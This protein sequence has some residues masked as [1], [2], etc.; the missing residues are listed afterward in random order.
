MITNSNNTGGI[1]LLPVQTYTENNFKFNTNMTPTGT[2]KN[3]QPG[4][5]SYL[6]PKYL[7]DPILFDNQ[8][9]SY[10]SRY[11]ADQDSVWSI[12]EFD[13]TRYS[14][15]TNPQYLMFNTE[16]NLFQSLTQRACCYGFTG[17]LLGASLLSVTAS[18]TSN[19]ARVLYCGNSLL[20]LGNNSDSP[21]IAPMSPVLTCPKPSLANGQATMI[22]L[23]MSNLVPLPFT[24]FVPGN[25]AP[26]PGSNFL[27]NQCIVQTGLTKPS[28]ALSGLSGDIK[29]F[30]DTGIPLKTNYTGDYNTSITNQSRTGNFNL[31]LWGDVWVP[32]HQDQTFGFQPDEF[33]PPVSSITGWD[34]TGDK[35]PNEF[36]VRA[37]NF[38]NYSY[39]SNGSE[40]YYYS[41]NSV[42]LN[43][44]G[45]L[46]GGN[47][48]GAGFS[49]FTQ[50][51][52]NLYKNK[53][54]E[55][56]AAGFQAY[57]SFTV[58]ETRQV[59]FRSGNTSTRYLWS[60]TTNTICNAGT[61]LSSLYPGGLQASI[62]N[63][64]QQFSY[65]FILTFSQEV[66]N[67]F[68]QL[69]VND[70]I[71]TNSYFPT[72]STR[73]LKNNNL[74]ASYTYGSSSFNSTIN[75]TNRNDIHEQTGI[76]NSAIAAN[77]PTGSTFELYDF[78]GNKVPPNQTL[79]INSSYSVRVYEFLTRN[80][81]GAANFSP[82]T[83][84]GMPSL[85]QSACPY[86]NSLFKDFDWSAHYNLLVPRGCRLFQNF[87]SSQFINSAPPGWTVD[88]Y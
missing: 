70:V 43:F 88:I 83:K 86:T 81:S 53:Y 19:T 51:V 9:A 28:L 20:S 22:P 34:P 65:N 46:W 66:Q 24:A 16:T 55:N 26:L 4:S 60:V 76:C 82:T 10:S 63:F 61:E 48:S 40:S 25:L 41:F 71:A 32:L 84:T 21:L 1:S 68:S 75:N 54:F 18:L 58:L 31:G 35:L 2:G 38:L 78:S 37:N 11:D 8:P 15:S 42:S 30:F 74:L 62:G 23:S 49:A 47:A 67:T 36:L 72:R 3:S 79:P 56:N 27:P 39:P 57:H 7:S 45:L 33:S 44:A 6:Y 59:D 29:T 17:Y 5:L 85:F 73:V 64:P 13:L 14:Q 87:N 50:S 12:T 69:V 77:C 80:V 52:P